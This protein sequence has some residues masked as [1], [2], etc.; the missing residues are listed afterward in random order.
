M[1]NVEAAAKALEAYTGKELA[2]ANPELVKEDLQDLITDLEHFAE[3]FGCAFPEYQAHLRY[4][5]EA[6]RCFGCGLTSEE[7][8]VE[9]AADTANNKKTPDLV[10]PKEECAGAWDKLGQAGPHEFKKA[11][12]RKERP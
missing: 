2:G 5:E 6:G 9:F 12:P 4:L 7:I 10:M 1:K 8:D 11:Q 3:A